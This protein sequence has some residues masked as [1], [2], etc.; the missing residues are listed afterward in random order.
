MTKEVS[1]RCSKGH[2]ITYDLSAN[3]VFSFMRADFKEQCPDNSNFNP[4]L[5]MFSPDTKCDRC[6][7]LEAQQQFSN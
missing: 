6:D 2:D 3:N 1:M 5:V 7:F 4:S